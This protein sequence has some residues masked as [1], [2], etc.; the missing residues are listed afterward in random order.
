MSQE[1]VEIVARYSDAFQRGDLA[2]TLSVLDE[3]V[4]WHDQAAIPGADV[5]RGREAV[6]RHIR[7]WLEAWEEIDYT[8]EE[9]LDRGNQVVVVVRRRGK[10]KGSG[11]EVNDQ[12]AYVLTVSSGKITRFEGF[13]DRAEALEAVELSE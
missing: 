6:G 1:N 7:Q 11:V 4:E 12:V 5:H 2:A 9:V 3:D 13:S 8:P 10:G